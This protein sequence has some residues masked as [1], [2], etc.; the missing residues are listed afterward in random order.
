M[1]QYNNCIQTANNVKTE[2]VCLPL[3]PTLSHLNNCLIPLLVPF[4]ARSPQF[5]YY[6]HRLPWVRICGGW[7]RRETAPRSIHMARAQLLLTNCIQRNFPCVLACLLLGLSDSQL[8]TLNLLLTTKD[9]NLFC[10]AYLALTRLIYLSIL[11]LYFYLILLTR[12]K[13]CIWGEGIWL[14][15]WIHNVPLYSSLLLVQ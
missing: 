8:V 11:W 2:L 9:L 1:K 10:H 3:S 7:A 15:A 4:L 13:L 14:F 6:L 5:Q 12:L